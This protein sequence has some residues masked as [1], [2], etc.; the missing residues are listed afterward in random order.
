MTKKIL[1][2]LGSLV[3]VAAGVAAV[4]AYE[5]WVVNV[6]AR[7]ENALYVHPESQD[8]GTMF[9]QEKDTRGFFVTTSKS[10]SEKEQTRVTHIDYVIKQKPKPKNPA[11][12]EWCHD[13]LPEGYY[14]NPPVITPL[15]GEY[16]AKCYPVLCFYLSKLPDNN[17]TPGNDGS[18]AAYHPLSATVPGK[19][20]KIKDTGDQWTIDLDVPCFKGECAQDWTHPNYEPPAEYDGYVF[21]CDI[22]IEVTK[23]YKP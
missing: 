11:D 23:I 22:W 13:N 1:L 8:F 3:V 16:L 2:I 15:P 17:P 7:I 20:D 10:F 5:A 18:L 14:Q 9:P 12:A 19:I 6:T 21:G 4:S